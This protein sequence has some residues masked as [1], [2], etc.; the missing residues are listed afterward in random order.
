MTVKL[1]FKHCF[2]VRC[3]ALAEYLWH[4]GSKSGFFVNSFYVR[5]YYNSGSFDK[6]HL[7]NASDATFQVCHC[8]VTKIPFW[9]GEKSKK[10]RD[11]C[12]SKLYYVFD[13]TSK[14]AYIFLVNQAVRK[15]IMPFLKLLWRNL[16][17]QELNDMNQKKQHM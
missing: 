12:T 15:Q 6:I 1:W 10:K 4:D 14:V 13:P 5:N 17:S 9:L 7:I 16:D 3:E 2:E 8:H 11:S